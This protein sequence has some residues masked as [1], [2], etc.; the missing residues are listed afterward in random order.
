MPVIFLISQSQ[1]YLI[2]KLQHQ[3]LKQYSLM[4]TDAID[5]SD[6]SNQR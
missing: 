6:K 3:E 1:S 4:G 5:A 2:D